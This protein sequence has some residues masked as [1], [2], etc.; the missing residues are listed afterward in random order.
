VAGA[1][2]AGVTA[3]LLPQRLRRLGVPAGEA[4][5]LAGT[6]H[7]N[8]G[9]LLAEAVLRSWWPAAAAAAL[10]SRR[11]RRVLAAATLPYLAGWLRA[12]PPVGP[13]PW[14]ALRLADD[15]AYGAG[16]WAGC[17]Q[18]RSLAALHPDLVG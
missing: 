13:L 1:L 8:A 14:L 5:R 9:R 12:R 17:W 2:T 10:A 11:T 7:A 18:A 16:V 3:G 15:L 4:L 6:G